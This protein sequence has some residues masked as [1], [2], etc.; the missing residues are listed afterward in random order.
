MIKLNRT[1][2]LYSPVGLTLVLVNYIVTIAL[3]ALIIMALN[4]NR[5]LRFV[6]TGK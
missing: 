4:K 6:L 3:T 1:P 2:V 5:I